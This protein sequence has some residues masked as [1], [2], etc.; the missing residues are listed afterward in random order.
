MAEHIRQR[1]NRPKKR[2]RPRKT[3]VTGFLV[4]DDSVHTKPKGRKM[5]G[6]GRHYS[7]TEK[8]VVT[9]HCLFQALYILL[10]RR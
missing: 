8:K 3:V 6:I 4:L 7:T 5:E 10:G 9:G 1:L 2:G